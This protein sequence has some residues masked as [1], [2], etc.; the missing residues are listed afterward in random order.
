MDPVDQPEIPDAIAGRARVRDSDI[1]ERGA[2]DIVVEHI[3]TSHVAGHAVANKGL[4][5][6]AAISW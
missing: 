4:F 2:R 1:A 6:T 5:E 3:Q